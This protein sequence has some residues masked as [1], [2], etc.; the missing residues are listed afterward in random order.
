MLGDENNLLLNKPISKKELKK[1]SREIKYNS[2]TMLMDLVKI[3]RENGQ[4]HAE[5]LWK[6]SK[7]PNDI[8]AFYAELK[9][10]VEQKKTIKESD[11]KGYLELV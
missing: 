5:D 2:K 8:D 3:L 10:Q 7:Y 11:K 4:L 9:N 6:M 1:P